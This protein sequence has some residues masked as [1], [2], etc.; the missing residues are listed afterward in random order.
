MP[1]LMKLLKS[2]IIKYS[3]QDW[4][5]PTDTNNMKAKGTANEAHIAP[6]ETAVK[7]SIK[8]ASSSS[9]AYGGII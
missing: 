5:I 8:S 1:I 3:D 6:S 7:F 4:F 2:Y 9:S